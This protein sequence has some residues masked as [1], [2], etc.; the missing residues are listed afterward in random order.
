[1]RRVRVIVDLAFDAIAGTVEVFWPEISSIGAAAAGLSL[2]KDDVD[3][4]TREADA[5][6]SAEK[7]LVRH[8]F[9]CAVQ[10]K[11][12]L[13]AHDVSTALGGASFWYSARLNAAKIGKAALDLE[14]RLSATPNE[15][16]GEHPAA[17]WRLELLRNDQGPLF[18]EGANIL[19]W[20]IAGA[21]RAPMIALD[22]S[23]DAPRGSARESFEKSWSVIR[24]ILGKDEHPSVVAA[25]HR[26]AA[27][28]F[29]DGKSDVAIRRWKEILAVERALYGS[30]H[31]VLYAASE[32]ELVLA[33]LSVDR[34]QEAVPHLVHAYAVFGSL[35]PEH[36]GMKELAYVLDSRARIHLNAQLT[37]VLGHEERSGDDDATGVPAAL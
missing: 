33:L 30:N 23:Q 35:A 22:E 4:L 19:S 31:H 21:A 18:D 36:R 27:A 2:S 37:K 28:E 9:W 29:G 24:R 3:A 17:R 8:G 26:L 12:I 13:L 15:R 11:R 34:I 32:T 20:Q 6:A 14:V 7:D 25:L 10:W 16:I 1:M 5:L